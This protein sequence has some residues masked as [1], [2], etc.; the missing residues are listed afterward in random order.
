MWNKEAHPPVSLFD[1]GLKRDYLGYLFFKG[2]WFL[3][4]NICLGGVVL[5]QT[6]GQ[7]DNLTNDLTGF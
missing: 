4:N 5:A 3:A 7:V 2:C 6:L 1:S